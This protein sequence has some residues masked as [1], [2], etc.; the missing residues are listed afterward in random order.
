VAFLYKYSTLNYE[1][2]QRKLCLVLAV[3]V[4]LCYEVERQENLRAIK[5]IA[6]AIRKGA[7]EQAKAHL[8]QRTQPPFRAY[9]VL[10]NSLDATFE[11]FFTSR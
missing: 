5:E 1:K 11:T 8:N 2:Q 10:P 3:L 9:L 7:S 4:S 6:M